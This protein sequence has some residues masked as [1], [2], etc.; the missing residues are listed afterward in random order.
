M[1][2]T[3]VTAMAGVLATVRALVTAMAEVL[4]TVLVTGGPCIASITGMA[5]ALVLVLEM[6]TVPGVDVILEMTTVPGVDMVLV[7]G[8]VTV[9]AMATGATF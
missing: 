2:V 6:T 7:T 1:E 4:A 5:M 8:P 9:S 3:L